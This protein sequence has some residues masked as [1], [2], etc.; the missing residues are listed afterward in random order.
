MVA[1]ICS[2]S[3]CTLGETKY[4]T[5]QGDR[6]M[7]AQL[8]GTP[9]RTLFKA[10]V[11]VAPARPTLGGLLDKVS[12]SSRSTSGK[13]QFWSGIVGAG[14]G[15]VALRLGTA[16][17]SGTAAAVAGGAMGAVSVGCFSAI[18]GGL[19]ATKIWGHHDLGDLAIGE[20]GA[21]V[22]GALGVAAGATAGAMMG[23][24]GSNVFG[25]IAGGLCG[26]IIG[27][28]FGKGLSGH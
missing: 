18:A 6:T 8:T 1:L 9:V 28:I 11:P 24:G 22:G 4:V 23:V 15:A 17:L 2:H 25:Y 10:P 12:L 5:M 14:V 7:I 16:G 3:G 21:I 27:G 19:I 20:A 13:V 26:A